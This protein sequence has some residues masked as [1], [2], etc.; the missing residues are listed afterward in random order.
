MANKFHIRSNSFPTG[1]HPSISRVEEE[2]NKLK[3]W[4]ATS[5]STSKSIGTGL[6]LLS[7]LHICL[8]DILNMASTQK[9]ISNHQGEKCIEELLDGSVRILDICDITRDTLLQIKEN[10]ESLHSALRRRKGDSS[11]ERIVAEYT[12]FSKKMKK[13]A[14]KLMTT[15]K[16]MENK[17]GVSPVLDEDQQLVSLI[18]VV[19]E[20]IGTNMSVFQSLLAFLVVPAS[21]S[22]AT[23]WVLVAKLMHK[24]VIACEEKQK[25]LNELQCVEASLSSLLSE[26]TN[27]ANMEAANERLEALENGIESIENGLE[28]VFRRMV[29]TRAC[30]LNI[31]TQ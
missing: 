20:V 7:D 12:L 15:L 3:T 19:R 24:G 2:L 26:G 1:S 22:K 23:K 5:T 6:S 4:E 30:L 16:Q 11:I 25:N 13:N 28:S 27:V 29:R 31:M 10:V 17:F 8:E 21:K 18:R 14:K 9:L